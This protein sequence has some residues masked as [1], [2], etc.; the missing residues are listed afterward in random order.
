MGTH[1][2]LAHDKHDMYDEHVCAAT[3]REHASTRAARN[4]FTFLTSGFL[5]VRETFVRV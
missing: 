5:R 2:S 4:I 3:A 1:I